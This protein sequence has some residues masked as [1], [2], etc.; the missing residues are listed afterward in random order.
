MPENT[1]AL[2]DRLNR[3]LE[4]NADEKYREDIKKFFKVEMKNLGVRSA[5]MRRISSKYFKEIRK[6]PKDEIF[7]I[8][9]ELLKSDVGECRGV[10]FDWAHRCKKHFEKSDFATFER[11]FED[12]VSNW[13]ACD[14]LC[15]HALGQFLIMYPDCF[16]ET[17]KWARSKKSMMRRASA[18][19]LIPTL[20]KGLGLKK[21]FE[22]SDILMNDEEDLVQK[23]FGWA[24]KEATHH[25]PH[26]V[27]EYV[28]AN[29]ARMPRTALRYAIEKLPE[30]MRR[31]A[32]KK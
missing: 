4:E 13:G 22:I 8:C 2:L 9:D 14:E 30:D 26:E 28:L 19:S 20:R 6:L 25:F 5:V 10:A 15:C 3:E 11:W 12:Y 18:V 21:I 29:R 27:Y 1:R 7:A 17:K 24:L 16:D 32:M 23:G 31:E